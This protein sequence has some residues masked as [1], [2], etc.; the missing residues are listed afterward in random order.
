[1]IKIYFIFLTLFL[2]MGCSKDNINVG[3]NGVEKKDSHLELDLTILNKNE[4][5]DFNELSSKKIVCQN[6]NDNSR[7][8]E[9][10][11]TGVINNKIYADIEFCK[12]NDN[13]QCQPI[14]IKDLPPNEK[15]KCYIVFSAM[16]GKVN[17]SILFD[18]D[19][20]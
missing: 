6:I 18:I 11:I 15:I 9:G 17:K 14:L 19:L 20:N 16:L 13:H 2:M 1:M 8:V 12:D 7:K 3:L 4:I 10:Y 5:K